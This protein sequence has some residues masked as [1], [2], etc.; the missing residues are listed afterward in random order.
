MA[1]KR[2]VYAQLDG[3]CQVLQFIFEQKSTKGFVFS[4]FI[5]LTWT[6]QAAVMWTLKMT[7]NAACQLPQNFDFLPRRITRSESL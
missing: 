6:P 7:E 1:W 2:L 5:N 3:N 4:V